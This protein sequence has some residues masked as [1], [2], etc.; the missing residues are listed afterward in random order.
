MG[1]DAAPALSNGG[2][3]V[4]VPHR[5]DIVQEPKQGG[6]V[7]EVGSAQDQAFGFPFRALTLALPL[8]RLRRR[9]SVHYEG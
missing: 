2:T 9:Q 5:G 7:S 4:R 8:R 3:E 6:V 1:G